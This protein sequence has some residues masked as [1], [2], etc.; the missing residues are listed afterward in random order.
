[1]KL[2]S[3]KQGNVLSPV[4]LRTRDDVR[5]WAGERKISAR[6]YREAIEG[7]YN[8]RAMRVWDSV[9]RD[10]PDARIVRVNVTIV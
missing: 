8:G 10:H 6:D 9:R 7:D 1:M 4:A 5:I 2:W 3:Y